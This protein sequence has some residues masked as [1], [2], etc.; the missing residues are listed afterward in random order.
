MEARLE[1]I[2][3]YID[4][5]TRMMLAIWQEKIDRLGIVHTGRLKESFSSAI[6]RSAEGR[7]I[8]MKFVDYGI[9]QALG[10]GNGYIRGNPGDLQILDETYREMHGLDK[11]RPAGRRSIRYMTSGYPRI[12]RDWY[13]RK[14]FLS[15]RVIIEA[16]AR[17][18]GEAASQVVCDQLMETRAALE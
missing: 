8:L 7:T 13:S 18:T 12:R 16:L 9:Y 2:D 14:L 5:W 10:T 3:K 6:T 17:I 1:D 11:P 15:H 4:E